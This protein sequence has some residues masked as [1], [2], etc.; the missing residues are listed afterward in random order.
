MGSLVAVGVCLIAAAAVA[1]LKLRQAV[2]EGDARSRRL[3]ER[4]GDLDH[5][6]S[7]LRAATRQRAVRLLHLVLDAGRR[8]DALVATQPR[9]TPVELVAACDRVRLSCLDRLR[10]SADLWDAAYAMRTEAARRDTLAA[11]DQLLREVEVAAEELAAAADRL[12]LPR[13]RG[14]DDVALA[15]LR[16]ELDRQLDVARRSDERIGA[17]ERS[18]G[19]GL[20]DFR[21]SA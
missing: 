1:V 12:Y 5:L 6:E 4:G 2:P 20:V 17:M 11:R 21:T 14:G 16:A 10:R 9:S 15:S 7:R 18:L 13:T 8:I 3:R 19:M